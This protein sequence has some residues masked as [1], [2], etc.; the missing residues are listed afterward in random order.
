VRFAETYRK[1][2]SPSTKT[3]LDELEV[4]LPPDYTAA[5]NVPPPAGYWNLAG[6]LY[7]YLFIHFS[8]LQI[9]IIGESQLIGY[10]S[11]DPSVSMMDWTTNQP[12][13]RFWVLKL[14]KGSF[15]PG[16]ELVDTN[17]EGSS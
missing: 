15:H 14:I 6:S 5:D 17:V 3:D 10:P 7:V 16:N 12:N 13:A 8:R 2:L 4:I 9:D 1:R 11:D